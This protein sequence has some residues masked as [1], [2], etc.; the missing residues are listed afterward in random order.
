MVGRIVVL[1]CVLLAGCGPGTSDRLMRLGGVTRGTVPGTD[2][3]GV[4]ALIDAGAPRMVL[5]IPARALAVTLL[6]DG[7]RDGVLRWRGTDNAQILTRDGMIVG[8]RGLAHDLMTVEAGALTAMIL[9]GTA[10]QDQRIH[11][12]LDG[13]DGMEIQSWVCD[14]APAGSATVRVGE[15]ETVTALKITETCHGPRGDFTNTH[16]TRGGRIIQSH[17]YAGPDLEHLQI[18]FLP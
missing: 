9:S 4:Q 10:G 17:Q 14:I 16:W 2:P 7:P 11:R 18:L 12:L 15:T 6:G 3:A 5:R 13:E 8:T 1:A